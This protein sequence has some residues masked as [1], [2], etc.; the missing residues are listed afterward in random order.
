MAASVW[1]RNTI[2][3][4]EQNTCRR[5]IIAENINFKEICRTEFVVNEFPD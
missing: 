1:T 4:K 3:S 2:Y 5:K